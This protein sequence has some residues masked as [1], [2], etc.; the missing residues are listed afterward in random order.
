MAYDLD[1]ISPTSPR[2]EVAGFVYS[3]GYQ[4]TDFPK[5]EWGER[6]RDYDLQPTAGLEPREKRKIAAGRRAR[7][8]PSADPKSGRQ[9]QGTKHEKSSA[10]STRSKVDPIS[11]LG[12]EVEL[13]MPGLSADENRELKLRVLA[14]VEEQVAEIQALV[15]RRQQKMDRLGFLSEDHNRARAEAMLKLEIRKRVRLEEIKLAAWQELR[16]EQAKAE[17][18][19][20]LFANLEAKLINILDAVGSLENTKVGTGAGELEAKEKSGR[21]TGGRPSAVKAGGICRAGKAGGGEGVGSGGDGSSLREQRSMEPLQNASEEE[22]LAAFRRQVPTDARQKAVGPWRELPEWTQR[23]QRLRQAGIED[24]PSADASTRT[25]RSAR[26]EFSTF[27]DGD[28]NDNGAVIQLGVPHMFGDATSLY[29]A[30]VTAKDS[31]VVSIPEGTDWLLESPRP[32]EDHL[33]SGVASRGAKVSENYMP[34]DLTQAQTGKDAMDALMGDLLGPATPMRGGSALKP[35]TAPVEV[36]IMPMAQAIG[37]RVNGAAGRPTEQVYDEQTDWLV[38]ENQAVAKEVD[39]M[40][41]EV[42]EPPNSGVDGETAG[43]GD[44][45]SLAVQVQSGPYQPDDSRAAVPAA[46]TS[47]P[48]DAAAADDV[49]IKIAMEDMAKRERVRKRRQEKERAKVAKAREKADAAAIRAAAPGVLGARTGSAGSGGGDM[50]LARVPSPTPLPVEVQRRL[51]TLWAELRM[52]VMEKLDMAVKYTGR[53]SHAL[54]R[55]ALP[56][57]ERAAFLIAARELAYAELSM[58][59]NEKAE[60][61]GLGDVT[62]FQKARLMSQVRAWPPNIITHA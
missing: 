33:M 11:L 40:F 62:A 43:T 20:G 1:K 61:G 26:S 50:A 37:V 38:A 29:G 3:R 36:S 8:M 42:R 59:L 27:S 30:E 17:P 58:L 13:A 39:E 46:P 15:V 32:G 21:R 9:W 23:T 5:I 12:P 53:D 19:E 35:E 34:Y 6:L 4:K 24:S 41:R 44:D 18:Q 14:R 55:D 25:P 28:E 60:E 2:D 51:E 56:K 52:P 31:N 48:L 54:V 47:G 7:R 45:G 49:E 10:G 22:L 16:R 57:W